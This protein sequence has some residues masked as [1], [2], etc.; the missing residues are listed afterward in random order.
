LN[1]EEYQIISITDD[2]HAVISGDFL[3]ESELTYAVIGAFTPGFIPSEDDKLIYEYDNYSLE[4]VSDED[5]PVLEENKYLLAKLY[6]NG[7]TL[8]VKDKR[9]QYLNVSDSDDWGKITSNPLMSLSSISKIEDN[10]VEVIVEHGYSIT[11]F[12]YDVTDSSI[13]IVSGTCNVLKNVLPVNLVTDYFKNWVILNKSN[14]KSLRITSNVAAVLDVEGFSDS[15]LTGVDDVLYVIPDYQ[16]IEYQFSFSGSDTRGNI[17]R[18]FSMQNI[19][20]RFDFPILSGTST[21]VIKG[22]M[23][24]K[25]NNQTTFENLAA[26]EFVNISGVSQTLINSSLTIL[27]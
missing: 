2:T 12:S 22:R 11:Q 20:N 9:Y 26:T 13:T 14:M 1:V 8:I 27:I 5:Q 4:I 21:V 19:L 18:K 17:Y 23:I 15:F 7:E 10:R 16:E 24:N 25:I 3:T 6:F